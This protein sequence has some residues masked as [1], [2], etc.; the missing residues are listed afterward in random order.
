[1]RVLKDAEGEFYDTPRLYIITDIS[2]LGSE[3]G[4]SEYAATVKWDEVQSKPNL[5]TAEDYAAAMQL[6]Q[7]VI[8]ELE[9]MNKLQIGAPRWH[10]STV[11][12]QHHAWINGDFIP[13]ADWPQFR[14]VYEEGGFAGMVLP[15]NANAATIAA[16]LGKWRPNAA[17]PTGLYT[18]NLGDQFLRVWVAGLSRAAGSWEQD[19]FQGHGHEIKNG[20]SSQIW[21]PGGFDGNKNIYQ[22]VNNINDS[23]TS[24]SVL[25]PVANGY[26]TPRVADHT[27][28]PNIASPVILYLGR[29][30]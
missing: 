20:F 15:Y 26:G 21:Q 7:A 12:P 29:A 6:L 5:V 18:P 10:R 22:G 28:P 23:L 17:S 1:V 3:A 14:E 30:A 25:S 13:F 19:A 27:R 9:F 16:N 24:G 11:L 4:Y 2:A 8:A